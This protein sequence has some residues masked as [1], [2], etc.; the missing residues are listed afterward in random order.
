MAGI[1]GRETL[2]GEDHNRAGIRNEKHMDG[3]HPIDRDQG[4]DN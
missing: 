2:G 1:R 4:T 3:G